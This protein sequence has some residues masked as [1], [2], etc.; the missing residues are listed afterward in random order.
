MR[1]QPDNDLSQQRLTTIVQDLTKRISSAA[2]F[3]IYYQL[4]LNLRT[5]MIESAEALKHMAL[6]REQGLPLAVSV[7]VSV[8]DLC[9]ERFLRLMREL[10]KTYPQAAA[11]LE[12]ECLETQ[13]IL[14]NERALIHL[15]ALKREGYRIAI[16]DFGAGYSN[17]GYLITMPADVIKIAR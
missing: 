2:G 5:G 14:H 7:N 6:W 12:L 17:L 9:S 8:Q 3:A 16:D 4:K 13:E 11:Q 1:Y 10:K 15:D